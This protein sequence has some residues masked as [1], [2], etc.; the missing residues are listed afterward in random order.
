MQTQPAPCWPVRASPCHS[1]ILA[2]GE[3]PLSTL[4]VFAVSLRG[5]FPAPPCL[6]LSTG[7]SQEEAW[8]AM[9]DGDSVCPS[10]GCHSV[11]PLQ[12]LCALTVDIIHL[13]APN[14]WSCAPARSWGLPTC[15]GHR[16]RHTRPYIL[17]PFFSQAPF[18]Q[19]PGSGC[20]LCFQI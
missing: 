18:A 12:P 6:E 4:S 17:A 15:L 20:G 10:G 16:K 5:C 13:C 19:F 11:P 1:E 9:E 7:G 8:E 3:A 14:T 2:N